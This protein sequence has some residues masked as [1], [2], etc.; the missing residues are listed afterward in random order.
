V[1]GKQEEGWWETVAPRRPNGSMGKYNQQ[2]KHR[3]TLI[4]NNYKNILDVYALFNVTPTS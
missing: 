1:E 2:L 3:T 4:N